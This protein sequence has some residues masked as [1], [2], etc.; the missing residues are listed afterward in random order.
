[1]QGAQQ[2]NDVYD[3]AIIGGGPAGLTA[4]IYA[5]R[6]RMKTV[7]V[8][9]V[10][11][12]G[13]LTMTDII[14]NYPGIDSINGYKL[15][16]DMKKQAV[17]FGMEARMGTVEKIVKSPQN[18]GAIWKIFY[19]SGEV[20]ALSVIIAS[21]ARARNL[22]VPG[23]EDL[24]GKGVSYCATC[25]GA[26]FKEKE[27]TVVGGGDTAIEEAVYLTR[28]ASKV[29]IIHRRDRLRAAR[30]LQER[31]MS[32]DK[33]NFIWDSVV[34]EIRGEGKV[35]GV[36][37]KN[38]KTGVNTELPCDGVFI[39]TGWKPN[40]EFLKGVLDLGDAGYINVDKSMRT[41]E[42]AIF[43]CGDCCDK[44]LY[45]VVTACG[46]GAI[47]ADAA[48]KYVEELKGTAYPA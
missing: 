6:A 23:E 41:D 15:V 47:A 36:L 37:L 43:A 4:G 35:Q 17:S 39:F 27:I 7:M 45:Q 22:G 29:N 44:P 11:V 13:Q 2:S 3:I 1:M 10:S 24:R 38:V 26:F 20:E 21:G 46:D 33:I 31:A 18:G 25:D 8:E 16:D 48:R 30:I 14:E 5:S 28:F 19:E 34:E 9:S 32:N 12:M 42:K 40:T